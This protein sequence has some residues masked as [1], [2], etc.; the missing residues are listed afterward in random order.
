MICF[1]CKRTIDPDGTHVTEI[2]N[3]FHLGCYE[4]WESIEDK[5]DKP[6]AP[7][8]AVVK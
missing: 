7:K 5:V 6:L 2:D 1:F 4:E 8:P 3:H